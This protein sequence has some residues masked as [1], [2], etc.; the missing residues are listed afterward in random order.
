LS[1]RK[2]RNLLTKIKDGFDRRYLTPDIL[3]NES[4]KSREQ[5]NFIKENRF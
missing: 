1:G 2:Y 5:A 4:A 3:L